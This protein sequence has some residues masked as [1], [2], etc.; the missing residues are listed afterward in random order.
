M[1]LTPTEKRMYQALAAKMRGPRVKVE[2]NNVKV[3]NSTIR[4]PA[5]RTSHSSQ[6]DIF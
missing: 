5:N 3:G 4:L 6:G 1:T 2:G